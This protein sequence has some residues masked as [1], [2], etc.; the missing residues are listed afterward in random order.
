MGGFAP[1][2]NR[3]SLCQD[4]YDAEHSGYIKAAD[5]EAFA[6]DMVA[7]GW[8]D[9]APSERDCSFLAA[10]LPGTCIAHVWGAWILLNDFPRISAALKLTH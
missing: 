10:L 1:L 8:K 6:K 4:K 5:A 2:T 9:W 3:D 7:S